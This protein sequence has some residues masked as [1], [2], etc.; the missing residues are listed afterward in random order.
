MKCCH[1]LSSLPIRE[2]CLH[3]RN[4]ILADITRMALSVRMLKLVPRSSISRTSLILR[5]VTYSILLLKTLVFADFH[6]PQ[7]AP[8]GR[9][10]AFITSQREQ[11]DAAD[12]SSWL[13]WSPKSGASILD[14]SSIHIQQTVDSYSFLIRLFLV[15]LRAEAARCSP[16][17]R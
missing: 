8:T 4:T 5:R 2:T 17:N 15:R 1:A 7:N 16:D 13:F 6:D 9:S 10:A 3:S 12:T 14:Q 11:R